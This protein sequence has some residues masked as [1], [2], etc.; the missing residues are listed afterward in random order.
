MPSESYVEN[1]ECS[2][3]ELLEELLEELVKIFRTFPNATITIGI[4]PRGEKSRQY[5]FKIL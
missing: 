3:V 1:K 4:I 5:R 2:F